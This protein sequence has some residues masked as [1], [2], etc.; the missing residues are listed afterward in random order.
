M[1]CTTPANMKHT[2]WDDVTDL[3][4]QIVNQNPKNFDGT[5]D[6]KVNIVLYP[7]L[8]SYLPKLHIMSFR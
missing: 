2:F 3:S 6:T 5:T 8:K 4:A 7:F 1:K